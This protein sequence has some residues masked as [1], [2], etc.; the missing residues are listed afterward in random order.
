MQQSRDI[1]SVVDINTM[2]NNSE[3][4]SGKRKVDNASD[5]ENDERKVEN[6]NDMEDNEDE[7]DAEELSA[8]DLRE[9]LRT[10]KR[11]KLESDARGNGTFFAPLE[12]VW[13]THGRGCTIE[14]RV[15][16][17]DLKREPTQVPKHVKYNAYTVTT[18]C[19]N[20]ATSIAADDRTSTRS[21]VDRDA[22]WPNDIF[23]FKASAAQVAH[24]VPAA[25]DDASTFWSVAICIFGLDPDPLEPP[26]PMLTVQ[27]L[28]HGSKGA[29]NKRKDHTGLK[30]FACNKIRLKGQDYHYDADCANHDLECNEKLGWRRV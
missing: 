12:E 19:A 27:K 25:P 4:K 20:E 15:F 16:F 9:R 22:I 10:V 6:S 17:S 24:L 7:D 1:V 28:I 14:D 29:G 13:D 23:G 21:G 30:H 3:E 2:N 8:E 18:H 26:T 5:M 11:L